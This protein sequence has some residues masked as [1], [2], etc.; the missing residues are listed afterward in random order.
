[1]LPLCNANML[2]EVCLTFEKPTV[3]IAKTIIIVNGRI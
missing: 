3:F 1:M 2:L